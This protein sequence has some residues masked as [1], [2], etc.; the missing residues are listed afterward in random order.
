MKAYLKR[1][2]FNGEVT[3]D[4]KGLDA[5]IWAHLTHIPF[6]NI[7]NFEEDRVPSLKLEDIYQKIV[8]DHRGG[9]CFE[10]NK[11]FYALLK[12]LGFDVIAVGVRI[13]WMR[14]GLT[15]ASHRASI[16]TIGDRKYLADVGYGGP[17]PKGVLELTTEEV[18]VVRGTRFRVIALP[19]GF[20]QI[21]REYQGG[22]SS[23]MYLED[24]E[25]VEAD[26]GI[27]NFYCAKCPDVLF[28]QKYVISICR[29]NGSIGLT[30]EMLT[31][32]DGDKVITEV[33]DTKEKRKQCLK[34]YFGIMR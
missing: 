4:A 11:L 22:F 5:L 14:E 32:K 24:R 16:V 33:I 29:E 13:I 30:G 27:M 19:D 3:L 25:A 23:M 10:L 7:E 12:E 28:T 18:Q 20:Y 34:K 8:G 2:D 9:Y 31:V 17:G 26:F 6:E 21:E 1:M 15:G